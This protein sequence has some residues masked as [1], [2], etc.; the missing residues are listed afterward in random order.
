MF[1]KR[2]FVSLFLGLG[3]LWA[4]EASAAE[5]LVQSTTEARTIVYFTADKEAV[6]KLLPAGW[7][8]IPG[9]GPLK[10]TNLLL[11]LAEG[12]AAQ[13]SDGKPVLYQGKNVILA[14]PAKDEKTGAAGTM[15]V[16]GFS[17]QPEGVPGAYGVYV[18][19]K[20]T[21]TKSSRSEGAGSTM[22]EETWEVSTEAGDQIRFSANYERGVGNRAHI[23]PRTYAA[24]KPEFYRIYKADQVTDLVH[25]V[26]VE[27]KRTKKVA[28]TGSGP[29]LSKVLSGKEQPVA[30]VS[31]PAYYRQIFLPE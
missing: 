26:A 22:V 5:R 20:I 13:D 16:G 21:M 8:S 9:T 28:F 18:P 23:E 11:V 29:Q 31:I 27:T 15:V 3:A 30:I 24:T 2:S 14:V 7:V 1:K 25:S 6:Q 4:A 10:D 17:S 19:A 12:L